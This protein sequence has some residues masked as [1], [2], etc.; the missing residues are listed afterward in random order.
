MLKNVEAASEGVQ[1]EIE[2]NAGNVLCFVTRH[3]LESRANRDGK[4]RYSLKAIFG[5]YQLEIEIAARS[6]S[7][8][9]LTNSDGIVVVDD[10]R[11]K[12]EM[13]RDR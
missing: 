11:T 4:A 6:R 8:L 10:L 1:F 13:D 5:I 7:E 2:D 9:A 3:A 12:E